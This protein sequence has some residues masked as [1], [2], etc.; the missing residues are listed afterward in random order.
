M[1]WIT[2]RG[3]YCVCVSIQWRPGRL[4]A[5]LKEQ[6][7]PYQTSLEM[8]GR[9]GDGVR[10]LLL[11]PSFHPY[12]IPSFALSIFLSYATVVLRSFPSSFFPTYHPS[13]FPSALSALRSFCS[14]PVGSFLLRS[15][16]P[17]CS[18]APSPVDSC[19]L[20]FL[21]HSSFCPIVL[22]VL[23]FFLSH[24]SF[25]PIVL[26]VP[27]FF[28]S[29][30]LFVLRSFRPGALFVLRSFRASLLPSFAPP[31]GLH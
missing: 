8:V 18:S 23:Q 27:S 24:R 10:S 30:A 6:A 25:R 28:S 5:P 21:S 17:L 1:D 2:W 29:R 26:S 14:S 13:L 4:F 9:V 7:G 3:E 15:F 12:F 11:L 19:P 20:L 31:S 22:S 16:I